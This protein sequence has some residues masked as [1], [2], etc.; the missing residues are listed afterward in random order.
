MLFGR[1]KEEFLFADI[2]GGVKLTA[3]RSKTAEIFVPDSFE[4]KPVI[5]IGENAFYDLSK[6]VSVRLPDSVKVIGTNAFRGCKSLE[7]VNLPKDAVTIGDYAFG[8]CKKL[9]GVTLPEGL[10]ELNEGVFTGCKALSSIVLPVNVIR[11][12]A[13]AFSGC[14]SLS[15]ITF[16][17]KPAEIGEN[18]LAGLSD[19]LSLVLPAGTQLTKESGLDS[20]SCV[21]TKIE[22]GLE[23]TVYGGHETD[24]S[25]PDS[26]SGLPVVSIGAR[27]FSMFA[28]LEKITLPAGLKRI[29]EG[30]FTGCSGLTDIEFPETLTEIGAGAFSGCGPHEA[31]PGMRVYNKNAELTGD[32]ITSLVF[33]KE[34][35]YIGEAAFAGCSA[36]ENVKFSGNKVTEIQSR[37]FA[38]CSALT[39]IALPAAVESIWDHAFEGC[40]A[41]ESI[42][43]PENVEVIGEGAFSLC[44]SLKSI[45]IPAK[46]RE[47]GEEAFAF[48]QSLASIKSESPAFVKNGVCLIDVKNSSLLAVPA[49]FDGEIVVPEG[50]KRIANAALSL[51]NAASVTVPEYVASIGDWAFRNSKIQF[52]HIDNP[53]IELGNAL[54]LG[55]EHITVEAPANVYDQIMA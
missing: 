47:I 9:D 20:C 33:P 31:R 35:S 10:T 23:L 51:S 40:M 41:L 26:F 44:V 50:V 2:E 45:F 19:T 16:G 8:G 11:I 52:L 28:Y 43:I 24:I 27:V 36:L 17:D 1:N 49:L 7:T 48:T 18:A 5:E 21:Y 12:G 6:A 15:S 32:G 25:L 37:C 3:C 53:D 4:G 39:D 38:G 46:V 42:N 30:A 13:E 22:D 34:L 29:G 54:I 55:S 14:A